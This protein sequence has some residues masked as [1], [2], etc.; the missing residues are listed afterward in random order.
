M[1][2]SMHLLVCLFI[3]EIELNEMMH[4]QSFS[5]FYFLVSKDNVI[6]MGVLW[7]VLWSS[8]S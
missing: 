2:M 6:Y 3:H 1:N 4:L 5:L 7:D 8:Y